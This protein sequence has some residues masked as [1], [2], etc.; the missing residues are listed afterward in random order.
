MYSALL[1]NSEVA[2]GVVMI[3]EAAELLEA[4]AL[5]SLSPKTKQLIMA[6]HLHCHAFLLITELGRWW[7]SLYLTMY[8]VHNQKIVK[9]GPPLKLVTQSGA[10]PWHTP[11]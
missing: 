10:H 7:P 9:I 4:H 8:G 2:P 11:C 1:Q 3:E 5:T 6:S